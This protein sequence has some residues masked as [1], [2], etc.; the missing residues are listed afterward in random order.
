MNAE[1]AAA[2]SAD[3]LDNKFFSGQNYPDPP[4]ARNELCMPKEASKSHADA[5]PGLLETLLKNY[6]Q[7]D[8]NFWLK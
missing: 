4:T 5:G 8:A 3:C 6:L 1:P 7:C 2:E